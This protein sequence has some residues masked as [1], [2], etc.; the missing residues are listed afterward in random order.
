[1]DKRD[2]YE[3]FSSSCRARIAELES[4]LAAGS[5]MARFKVNHV[6]VP[7]AGFI[8]CDTMGLL[9]R[10]HAGGVLY[11]RFERVQPR[12]AYY[13][14]EADAQAVTDWLTERAAGYPV[15]LMLCDPTVAQ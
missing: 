11:N 12:S 1:M 15:N 14:T 2:R 8:V 7:G 13:D 10:L 6:A 9:T 4:A 3:K 5:I